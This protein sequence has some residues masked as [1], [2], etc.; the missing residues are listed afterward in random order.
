MVVCFNVTRGLLELVEL[1]TRRIDHV[2]H[3]GS[4]IAATF[5]IALRLRATA[6][7]VDLDS[8]GVFLLRVGGACK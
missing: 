3:S 4:V 6:Q 5:E 2:S 1:R 8:V 7:I